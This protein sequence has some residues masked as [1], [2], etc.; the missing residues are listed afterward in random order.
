MRIAVGFSVLLWEVYS[1][2]CCFLFSILDC[3]PDDCG[4]CK[5]LLRFCRSEKT[6]SQPVFWMPYRC[7]RTLDAAVQ[8]VLMQC[9]NVEQRLLSECLLHSKRLRFYAEALDFGALEN[10]L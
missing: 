5:T 4:S 9:A 3:Y 2:G 1:Q 7:L 8:D 6:R 10:G